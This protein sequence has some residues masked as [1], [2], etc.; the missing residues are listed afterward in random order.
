M[1]VELDQLDISVVDPRQNEDERRE[2]VELLARCRLDYERGVEVFVLFY[3]D[4]KLIACAGLES[5]VVKDVAILPDCR[6]A[7]IGLRLLTEII[8]LATSRGHSHLFLYTA[9]QNVEFFASC[10]FYL[11][12]EAPG[13]V[14]LMENTP[15]G[16]SSYCRR[17][18][19]RRKLGAKIGAV[20]M[21]ANPFTLGHRYLV[22]QSAAQ[23]DWLHV[24]VVREDVSFFPYAD[25]FPLVKQGVEG[26][27]RVTVHEGSAYMVSRATFSAYFFKEKGI[28]GDCFTAID[29]LMFRDYI[30]PALGVTH[31]FVGT[32]PFCA[33]TRKYNEDMKYWLAQ[34]PAE[35]PAVSVVEFERRL[36]EGRPI[37]A[38][39]VRS[40]LKFGDFA[41]IAKLVP[42]STFR[43]LEMKY[44]SVAA[45]AAK[46]A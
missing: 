18:A 36:C 35:G 46:I 25:R 33:T 42:P 5:N 39:E 38:S 20:V 27:E 7:A 31:R 1:V 32:E 21:N 26:V 13:Y 14:A 28:V 11:L 4:R 29:L 40:C 41:T 10:G 34:A 24:F 43:L 44:R 8:N 23:C 16:A 6:G 19:R 17:L 3:A 22:E 2:I 9:P 30:A 12:A 37:S 45:P 15:I